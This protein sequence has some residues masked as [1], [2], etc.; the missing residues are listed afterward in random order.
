MKRKAEKGVVFAYL[1]NLREQ[2]TVNMLDAAPLIQREFGVHWAIAG[3]LLAEW[4]QTGGMT[5]A[6]S[7]QEV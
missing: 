2:G 5:P 4:I 1:D 6:L 7:Q 3:L